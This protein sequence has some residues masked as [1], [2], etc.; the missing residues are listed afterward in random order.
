MRRKEGKR[1]RPNSFV[2]KAQP[3]SK[4]KPENIK[5]LEGGMGCRDAIEVIEKK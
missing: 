1:T 5:R 2:R 4:K 3:N